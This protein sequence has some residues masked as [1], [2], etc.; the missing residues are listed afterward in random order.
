VLEAEPHTQDDETR[1]RAAHLRHLP[2]TTEYSLVELDLSGLLP[3]SKASP[4]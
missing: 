1:R 4:V 3:A 2:L